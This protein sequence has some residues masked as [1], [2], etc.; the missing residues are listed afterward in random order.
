MNAAM[1]ETGEGN[2]VED[3]QGASGGR[4]AAAQRRSALRAGVT[5]GVATLA[6][7][8]SLLYMDGV[9]VWLT[10]G[11]AA[12]LS[13]ALAV[14]AGGLPW[15]GERPGRDLLAGLA[16]GVVLVALTHA[17]YRLAVLLLPGL[18][19]VVGELYRDLA[20]PPGPVAA[21]PLTALVVLAEE[22][23]WRG[24]LVD[25]LES[26]Y[27]RRR[28]GLHG[29][30]GPARDAHRW[31]RTTLVLVAVLTY[32]VPHLL[33]GEPILVAAALALGAVWTALRLHTGALLA[34]FACHL[35][36]S[37]TIFALWP[38]T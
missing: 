14:W 34:P 3:G 22:A 6:F 23:V 17:A 20:V 5:V 27:R 18:D 24:V 11:G 36:W 9:N 12:V 31:G 21:L 2:G 35:T 38:L 26:R 16:A 32:A 4:A 33:A 37:A 30:R 25:R 19:G 8:L 28:G 10:T 13:L 1:E 7:W 29:D 15:R